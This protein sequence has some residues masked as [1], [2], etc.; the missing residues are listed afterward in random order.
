MR[1][2]DMPVVLTP[3]LQA[4]LRLAWKLLDDAGHKGAAD[5]LFGLLEQRR[6]APAVNA[7]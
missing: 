7:T 5:R 4:D 6:A 2:D 1:T 3:Q